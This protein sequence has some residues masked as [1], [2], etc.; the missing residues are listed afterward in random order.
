MEEMPIIPVY[1][2]QMR[3]VKHEYLKGVFLSSLGNIDFKC[4]Y[5][6]TAE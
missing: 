6:E 2:P 4:A 5:L 3:Y 1:H